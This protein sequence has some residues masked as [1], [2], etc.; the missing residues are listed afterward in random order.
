MPENGINFKA[1]PRYGEF[2]DPLKTREFNRSSPHLLD[3]VARAASSARHLEISFAPAGD[4]STLAK[5]RTAPTHKPHCV[6]LEGYVPLGYVYQV[7]REG[8]IAT[9]RVWALPR[10]RHLGKHMSE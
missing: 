6:L 7:A 1:N 5:D 9:T 3:I 2:G 4:F 10:P 8:M